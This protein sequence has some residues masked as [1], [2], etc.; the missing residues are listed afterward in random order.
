MASFFIQSYRMSQQP[1]M[2]D[3]A[4][5]TQ[6][7]EPEI[8]AVPQMQPPVQAITAPPVI[9]EARPSLAELDANVPLQHITVSTELFTAVLTNAGGDIIS[10]RWRDQ[11]RRD[12]DADRY[13]ELILSGAN[14]A[15]AFSV[16]FDD[17]ARP[18]TSNF[19]VNQISDYSVEFYRDFISPSG[20]YGSDG[21][22][23][24]IKRYDFKPNEFMFELTITL[25]GGF[26]VPGFNF[27]GNAYIL[28]FGPQIGPEFIRLD[29]HYDYRHYNIYVNGRRRDAKINEMI[30]SRPAWA[31]ISGKYFT[32]IA[33]PYFAQYSLSFS[34]REEMGLAS[35][36]RLNIFRPAINASRI[37]D[38]YRFYIGPKTQEILIDYNTGR[39]DFNIRDANLVEVTST[40]GFWGIF[41]PLE[42]VLKWLL[43]GIYGLVPNYGI[44][45]ILLTLL[46][47]I[48]FFPLTKKGSEGTL[49]MQALA[50]KIK[51]LQEKHKGNPQKLQMEMANFYKQ[52][53]YNPLS[54]CLPMLL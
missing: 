16:S 27:A 47:K 51:E 33:L 2:P 45:I 32:F 24:L 35:T 46:I 43:L 13:V 31:A 3:T 38:T 18:V 40:R 15:R 10:F 44:A 14:E 25:D 22:F 30:D 52:E 9:E 53:G 19:R 29:G 36:S 4:I 28:S 20:V 12:D 23:R 7:V 41:S 37:S 49:R 21:V 50:P 39:N 5:Q 48:L 17:P 26:S 11:R 54:G 6:P 1:S 34:E 8:T 42:R